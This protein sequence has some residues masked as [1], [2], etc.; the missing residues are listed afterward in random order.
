[1]R[2]VIIDVSQ[3]STVTKPVNGNKK[4]DIPVYLFGDLQ[5]YK[6]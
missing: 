4:I 5:I 3:S 6:R 2:R 1:M